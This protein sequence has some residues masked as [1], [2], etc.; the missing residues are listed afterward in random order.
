MPNSLE[1]H[2][3]LLFAAKRIG[4]VLDVGGHWGEYGSRL[5]ALGYAGRIVSFEP[6]AATYQRLQ[7]RAATDPAWTTH[8]YALGATEGGAD[9]NIPAADDFASL[10]QPTAY[11]VQRFGPVVAVQRTERIAVKRL[12]RVFRECASRP[13]GSGVLLK[14]DA[15]GTDLDVV[16]GA[17]AV[18]PEIDA[19]QLEL[20]VIP[21]YQGAS[22][23]LTAAQRLSEL[24]YDLS[25]LF[26]VSRDGDRLRLI[27]AD[28]VFVRRP[29]AEPALIP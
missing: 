10:L 21:L 25:G 14:V 12:D 15:Q 26:P 18:L 24:G 9:I 19:I 16:D 13:A 11:A 3:R 29:S 23:F 6:V 5:R 20:S 7:A 17:A 8:Q 1:A 2:L 27:D 28:C 4:V 22:S